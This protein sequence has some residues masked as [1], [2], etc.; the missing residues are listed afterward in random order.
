MLQFEETPL[1]GLYLIQPKRFSDDRGYFFESYNH[2]SYQEICPQVSFV[3]DNIS[4]SS[5]GT[6]RGLH[7]QHPPFQQGKLVTVLQGSVLDVAVDLRQGSKTYGQ[8]FKCELSASNGM[9]LYIP[10]GFA[11]GFL[12]LEDNTIFAYKC[13]NKYM[14][15]AENCLLWNDSTLAIDWGLS[16]APL[17][18]SKDAKGLAFNTFQSPFY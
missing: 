17:L 16:S 1:S 12:S 4:K 7:F 13:T 18:S 9:Q 2:I 14:Q 10:E 6:L 8:H 15:A 5:K 3:Q 11:H